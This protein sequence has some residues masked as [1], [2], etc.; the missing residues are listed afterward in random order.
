[1]HQGVLI[2]VSFSTVGDWDIRHCINVKVSR[3]LLRTIRLCVIY[4]FSIHLI[5]PKKDRFD[6]V[7]N[8]GTER[9]LF[10][11]KRYKLNII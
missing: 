7:K 6:Y 3:R 4:T 2:I 11:A 1:M 9:P 8:G 5:V 10:P